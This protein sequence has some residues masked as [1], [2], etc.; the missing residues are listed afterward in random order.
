MLDFND[1]FTLLMIPHILGDFYF[2]SNIMASK[3]RNELKWVVIHSFIYGIV[4]LL[5]Y[6]LIFKT[7]NYYFLLLLIIAHALID[8]LKYCFF[9]NSCSVGTFIFDQLLHLLTIFIIAF[10]SYDNGC[11]PV[12]KTYL[13]RMFAVVNY[14]HKDLFSIFLK[15]LLLH[16]PTNIFISLFMKPYKIDDTDAE[17]DDDIK[18]GR[19]I[20]TLERI[21]M[22]FFIDINQYS[23]IG[24]VLTAKSI[25]RYDKIS[26]KQNFAEYYLLGTLLSTISI[27]VISL[28]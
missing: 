13:M 9:S 25:A 12:F 24:L 8:F 22:M 20:G 16:K 10:Y 17:N 7:F 23:S 14:S 28:I 4:T 27:L 3:K 11:I 5:F 18:A 1:L 6:G 2:Q 15:L 19:I 26:K 21:I